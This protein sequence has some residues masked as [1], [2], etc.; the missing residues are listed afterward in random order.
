MRRPV[1]LRLMCWFLAV[2]GLHLAVGGTPTPAQKKLKDLRWTHAF[3]LACRK[4][5]ETKFTQDT[6]RIGVEAF[7]DNGCVHRF[8]HLYAAVDTLRLAF[9]GRLAAG[10]G[11]SGIRCSSQANTSRGLCPKK[12]S[13]AVVPSGRSAM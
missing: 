4:F 13:A 3:D 5:G 11:R 12:R 9:L 10:R 2:C 1:T 6:Q 8:G 7:Q